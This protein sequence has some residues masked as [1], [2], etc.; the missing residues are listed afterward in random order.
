MALFYLKF[1]QRRRKMGS[2]KAFELPSKGI[3]LKYSVNTGSVV[4]RFPIS[5]SVGNFLG[6]QGDF[7]LFRAF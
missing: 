4:P 3:A 7:R 1:L 2:V 6:S 5:I